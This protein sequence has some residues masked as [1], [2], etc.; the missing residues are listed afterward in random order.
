VH[1]HRHDSLQA[2]STLAQ[3]GWPEGGQEQQQAALELQEMQRLLASVCMMAHSPP[4]WCQA[5]ATS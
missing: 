3:A 4:G 1:W 2:A 5:L